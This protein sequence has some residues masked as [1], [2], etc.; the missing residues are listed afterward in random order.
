LGDAPHVVYRSDSGLADYARHVAA[1]DLFIGGSSGPL[2]IAGALDRPTAAFYPRRRSASALRWQTLNSEGRRLS[3]MPPP[4]A[5]ESDYDA[6]DPGA[7]IS[8]MTK[9]LTTTF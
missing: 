2:H 1:A 5:G 9:L 4:D 8:E 3:F 6:I 7:A